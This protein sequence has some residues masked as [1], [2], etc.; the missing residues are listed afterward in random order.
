MY[1]RSNYDCEVLQLKEYLQTLE[2]GC[3]ELR[4]S[5]LF[6]K[7]LEGIL[8][9]GNRMNAGT[10]RGN[11]Q[12]FNLSALR[13]LS[14]VKSTDGKTSL[15]HFIVEQVVQSEG[16]RKAIY[17]SHNLHRSKIYGSNTD[18]L[19]QQERD[20]EYQMLGLTVLGS[21][22]DELSQVKRAASIDH[23]SFINS[24]STLNAHVTE[25]QQIITQSG[26]SERGEFFKEIKGFLE[27]C[28]HELKVV[29]EEETRIMELVNRTNKY[30]LAGMSKDHKSNPFQLF[31][32][33]KDFV[34][35]VDQACMVLKKKLE[36]KNVGAEASSIPPLSPS[37]KATL[38]FPNFEIHYLSSMPDTSSFSQSDDDF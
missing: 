24:F 2:S 30:Y 16:K 10:S 29:K 15:L 32:I 4:T 28:E 11:A 37:N 17:Q 38:R 20:R 1:F 23:Q 14:D 33:V 22:S 6:L 5:G 25:I 7:L 26:N 21:L 18:S 34:D 9:A 13:K 8:K 31:L 3:K 19:T 36:K 12:G 35:M 27:E